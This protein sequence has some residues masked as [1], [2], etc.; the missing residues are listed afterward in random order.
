M[1][2]GNEP[3]FGSVWTPNEEE[4]HWGSRSVHHLG[5]TKREYFAGLAMQG[6]L[7]GVFSSQEMLIFANDVAV[8]SGYE[9]YSEAASVAS[10][11]YADAL[12]AELEKTNDQ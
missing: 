4:R 11:K 8:A 2:K 6:I 12:L 5:L 9:H 7:S 1:S 10:V 3:A